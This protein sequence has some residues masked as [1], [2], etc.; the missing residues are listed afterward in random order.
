MKEFFKEFREREKYAYSEAIDFA[1]QYA[2][3][4][5]IPRSQHW[6]IF[7]EMADCAKRANRF[8]D[9]RDWYRTV[10][11][12]ERQM[13]HGWLEYAKMEEEC[14][15]LHSCD[16]LLKEAQGFSSFSDTL[17]IKC[18]KYFERV[19]D[20]DSIK[21]I[22]EKLESIDYKKKWKVIIEGIGIYSHLG[23]D[24]NQIEI[25]TLTKRLPW[26]SPLFFEA[27]KLEERTGNLKQVI[28]LCERGLLANSRFGP[29]WFLLFQTLEKLDLS[30]SKQQK[31]FILEFQ[32][33]KSLKTLF[34]ISNS[35]FSLVEKISENS[36]KSAKNSLRRALES[37]SKEVFWKVWVNI[38]LLFLKQGDIENSRKCLTQACLTC[39]NGVRWKIWLT[40]VRYE[41]YFQVFIQDCVT[42]SNMKIIK[43]IERA[44]VDVPKKSISLVLIELSKIAEVS[45]EKQE[46]FEVLNL[47][48]KH[49]E[50]DWRVYL[51]SANLMRRLNLS[52]KGFYLLGE[53]VNK[54]SATG[55]LWA[56]RISLA[57]VE[58]YT[59]QLETFDVALKHVPKSGEVWCEGA[60]ICLNPFAECFSLKIA[61]IRLEFAIQ[62]TPQ[63]GDSFVEYIR[64]FLLSLLVKLRYKTTPEVLEKEANSMKELKVLK[65]RC[66]NAAP[67]Y[68][69][70][71]LWCKKDTQESCS[72]VFDRVI[73]IL[74]EELLFHK[75]Q[76]LPAVRSSLKQNYQ[77][78]EEDYIKFS[79]GIVSAGY[80][81][82]NSQ[83]IKGYQHR[84]KLVY[85][86]DLLTI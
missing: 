85:G 49:S 55:R 73:K 79:D 52:K 71:W 11:Q 80:I 74:C 34:G 53:A 77:L 37:V 33:N 44:L 12:L 27:A 40:A 41:L 48:R 46:A 84:C 43:L 26:C 7:L 35:S 31:I 39:P 68:G 20:F 32:D 75:Q 60:K 6:K 72:D 13:P 81:F 66:V 42:I 64:L 29:L 61:K 3:T 62:F 69:P 5:L 10:L 86:L 30:S 57:A 76:Y 19:A 56:V 50:T 59:I 36:F 24:H 21:Q 14:G 16:Y 78:A 51:E 1:K 9:A 4:D 45:G 47:A 8:R 23:N 28:N 15:R 25:E 70:L 63:Y 22:L 65:L 38:S 2:A 83:N 18:M 17:L 82:T 58:G 54:F 67:N